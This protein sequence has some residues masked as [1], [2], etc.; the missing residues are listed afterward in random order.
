METIYYS[1]ILFLL[2]STRTLAKYVQALIFSDLKHESHML[3][4]E[5]NP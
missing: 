5:A 2:T 3:A 4:M 1:S